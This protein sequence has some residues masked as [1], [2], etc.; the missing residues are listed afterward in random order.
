MVSGKLPNATPLGHRKQASLLGFFKKTPSTENFIENNGLSCPSSARTTAN[1]ETSSNGP[2]S[3]PSHET[4][5]TG[6]V[7]ATYMHPT[8]E[9]DKEN[10]ETVGRVPK[11][12]KIQMEDSDDE[13]GPLDVEGQ[14]ILPQDQPF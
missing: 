12:R 2:L 13:F 9:D 8:R 1:F 4:P 10:D 14:L 6:R 11:R 3:S 7:V 5:T